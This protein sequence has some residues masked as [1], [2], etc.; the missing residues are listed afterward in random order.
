MDKYLVKF[1]E[2]ARLN[3]DTNKEIT[4]I[5]LSM[6]QKFADKQ[7][8]LCAMG[9][10]AVKQSN[11]QNSQNGPMDT[12]VAGII[13]TL[14]GDQQYRLNLLKLINNLTVAAHK[15]NQEKAQVATQYNALHDDLGTYLLNDDMNNNKE[16]QSIIE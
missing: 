8:I 9:Q 6:T 13:D 1:Y 5:F 7:K 2:L 11:Y 4:S 3:K 16:L 10:A 12:L 14:D 15:D